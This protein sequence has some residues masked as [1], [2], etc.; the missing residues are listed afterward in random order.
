MTS[1]PES[2][3]GTA[4]PLLDFLK[5]FVQAFNTSWRPGSIGLF[6]LALIPGYVIH[7][8]LGPE[9]ATLQ[10]MVG[11]VEVTV[12]LAIGCMV[13]GTAG[14]EYG[15]RRPLTLRQSGR[16]LRARARSLYLAILFAPLAVATL[17]FILALGSLVSLIPA[18]IG[19]VLAVIWLVV[20][21]LPAGAVAACVLLLGVP[22]IFLMVPAAALDFPDP[23]DVASR[24]ISYVRGRCGTFLVLLTLSL[25]RALF[26]AL[27]TAVF[28][29]ILS[30]TVVTAY[31]LGSF[32]FGW[33]F[34]GGEFRGLYA[35]F[36][37]AIEFTGAAAVT[38]PAPLMYV[39]SLV[40]CLVPASFLSALASS[41]A[42]TYLYLRWIFDQ[43]PPSALVRPDESFKWDE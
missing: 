38:V 36:A 3:G 14:W 19:D 32:Q 15:Q 8:L 31:R 7:R 40:A 6:W 11:V 2:H 43:E 1:K 5:D 24:A 27:L 41:S 18:G 4:P 30:W 12:F 23:F 39:L 42:R 16:L 9:S 17:I 13:A 26:A 35:P 20:V 37:W 25:L 34:P 22:A 33:D 10:L 28:V 29:L 21:G